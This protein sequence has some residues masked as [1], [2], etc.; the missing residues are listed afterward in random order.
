M[1]IHVGVE[2]E[3]DI[4]FEPVSGRTIYTGSLMEVAR[5][6]SDA[7]PG[8]WVGWELGAQRSWVVL[9]CAR[10]CFGQ[11]ERCQRSELACCTVC[12]WAS[13]NPAELYLAQGITYSASV[14]QRAGE[15]QHDR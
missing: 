3:E 10:V 8:G 15:H 5:A 1:G 9:P 12:T 11:M 2:R 13:S 7:A 4:M 6:V 14:D